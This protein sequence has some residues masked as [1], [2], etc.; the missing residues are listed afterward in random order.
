[1]STNLS[2]AKLI[3]ETNLITPEGEDS[4]WDE[5]QPWQ[6]GR[7]GWE[8]RNRKDYGWTQALFDFRT[9]F[10]SQVTTF[11]PAKQNLS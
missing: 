7:Q 6:I 4:S 5:G 10:K 8:T 2:S 9:I 11:Q 1:M 3:W